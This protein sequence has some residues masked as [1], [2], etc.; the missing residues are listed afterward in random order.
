LR[1]LGRRTNRGIPVAAILLQQAIVLLL[2]FT[3]TFQVALVYVQF[4]LILC[5]FLTVLGM[6]V[7]RW[8]HPELPRPYKTWG[9]PF[10]PL[11]FL[12][13]SLWMMGYV[14][15]S[16]PWES[17]AGLGTL[18]MGL[19]IYFLSPKDRSPEPKR[20]SEIPAAI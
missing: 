11:V 8:T 4:T 10:T 12:G 5:S 19:L 20:H 13:V 3:A 9:Y 18:A 1:F 6:M 16:Q 2:I 17:L 15:K 7:L 14:I